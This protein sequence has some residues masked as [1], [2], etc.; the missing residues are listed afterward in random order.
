M[1]NLTIESNEMKIVATIGGMIGAAVSAYYAGISL[2]QTL[3]CV[4]EG[5]SSMITNYLGQSFF[6]ITLLA[7]SLY[8]IRLGNPERFDAI[9][10]NLKSAITPAAKPAAKRTRK[11][12]AK[13]AK[14][15]Q[16]AHAA[17]EREC[18]HCGGVIK[19]RARVCKHCH[20]AV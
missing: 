16:P 11:T 14:Q 20:E 12:K 4:T 2:F 3:L 15:A 17:D 19:A 7:A 5:Y 18:P 6:W 10:A 13:V 8:L 9:L 1:K